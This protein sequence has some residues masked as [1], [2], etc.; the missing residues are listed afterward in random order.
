MRLNR[1]V[2]PKL[3]VLPKLDTNSLYY[4]RRSLLLALAREVLTLSKLFSLP[5]NVRLLHLQS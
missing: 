4:G 2:W 1:A 3:G 5:T